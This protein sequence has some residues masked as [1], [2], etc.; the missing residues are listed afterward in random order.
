MYNKFER[1]L[2]LF[3]PT[4]F[5]SSFSKLFSWV[6]IKKDSLKSRPNDTK[7]KNI[8]SFQWELG[9]LKS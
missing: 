4:P 7:A 6:S 1:I 5:L 2:N 9:K 3:K 8:T